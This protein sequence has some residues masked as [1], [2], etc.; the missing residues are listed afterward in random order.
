MT[1][2]VVE[3]GR[4]DRPRRGTA[5]GVAAVLLL[6][7]AAYAANREPAAPAPPGATPSAAATGPQG[8]RVPPSPAPPRLPPLTEP[9]GLLV[10]AAG[11][12]LT[13]VDLDAGDVTRTPLPV[14]GDTQPVARIPGGWLVFVREFCRAA[15]CDDRLYAVRDGTA[16]QVGRAEAA[17]LDPDGASMWLTGHSFRNREPDANPP[18]LER[19]TLDGRRL[20]RR[21]RL[22]PRERLVGV[23]ELGPVTSVP[24]R[25][26][27]RVTQREPD[28]AENRV[29][30][31]HG[32]PVAVSPTALAWLSDG[33]TAAPSGTCRLSVLDVRTGSVTTV[34]RLT[35]PVR[36]AAFTATGG[37]L[38]VAFDLP[39]GHAEDA[40]PAVAVYD[41]ATR[42]DLAAGLDFPTDVSALA[43][44]PDDR[45]LVLA[46]Q[47]V[48]SRTFTSRLYLA[49]WWEGLPAARSAPDF[50]S[51]GGPFVAVGTD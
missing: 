51:D 13:L 40:T 41:V 43:W 23:T 27:W 1:A 33:C 21:V 3:A 31:T 48:D 4:P 11:T 24:A 26:A 30:V 2:E 22:R 36:T 19:R 46:Q 16:T 12:E 15:H 25:T 8:S 42:A 29:V 39:G 5:A 9:T 47:T 35:S 17:F 50:D 34:A 14:P 10:A 28:G 45:F 32:V 7:G 37:R 20:T 18:W 44:S 49:V 6:A 38:A